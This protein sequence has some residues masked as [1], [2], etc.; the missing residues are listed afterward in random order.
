MRSSML[1]S[2]ILTGLMALGASAF[3]LPG[4]VPH[5]YIENEEVELKVMTLVF[6]L[7]T[8][9]ISRSISLV[10]CVLRFHMTT[11]RSNFANLKRVSSPMRRT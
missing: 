3:Y 1:K 9:P 8:Q 4:V 2:A 10:Q 6:G 7:S 5:S 11:I